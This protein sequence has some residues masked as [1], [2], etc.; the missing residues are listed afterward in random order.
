M[1]LATEIARELFL[2]GPAGG[3]RVT[4]VAELVR[5]SGASERTIYEH[6]PAWRR[7]SEELAASCKESG[8]VLSLSS[9][10]LDAH[11][12]DCDFLRE[13]VERLKT[14]LRGLSPADE[15]YPAVSRAMLATER[16]WA[17]MA[18]ISAALDAAAARLKERERLEARA[19]AAGA[20]M[21]PRPVE[22][23]PRS[24]GV[25]AKSGGSR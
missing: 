16:Q 13:E 8:L 15:S 2:Y 19:E 14:H 3:R 6:L 1:K 22:E 10:A 12:A 17:A 7:E 24:L 21:P 18:G 9:S 4:A 25:F 11:K 5:L 23:K 20:R